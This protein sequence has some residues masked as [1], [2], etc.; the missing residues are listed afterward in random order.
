[1]KKITS[2]IL[3]FLALVVTGCKAEPNPP[4]NVDH[5]KVGEVT[6]RIDLL[7]EVITVEDREEIEAITLL[8][9]ALNEEEQALVTNLYILENAVAVISAIDEEKE[10]ISAAFLAAEAYLKE[11]VP[12]QIT[13]H[14]ELPTTYESE[15]GDISILWGSSHPNTL[16]NTGRVIQGRK[17]SIVTL[18]STLSLGEERY[19]F[20]Q[21]VGVMKIT[22]DPLPTERLSFGY[23]MNRSSF[24]GLTPFQ[25]SALDVINYS[26]GTVVNG[27]VSI[28]G[29]SM[30]DKVLESRRQGV[31]V[32]L[33]LGGYENAA[34]PFS[35]AAQTEAGRIK[36]AASVVETLETYHFD[37]IDMDWEYPGFYSEWPISQTVDSANYTLLMQEIRKQVKIANPDYII[38]AALPGGPYNS[39][40]FE[41]GNLASILDFVHL[42][43]YDLD[44]ADVSTHLTALYPSANTVSKCTVHET[45]QNYMENGMA[46]SQLVVGITFYGREFSLVE[47]AVNPMRSA[48]SSR[49]SIF[50]TEIAEYYLPKIGNG[51]TRYWDAAAKAPYLYDSTLHRTISYDDPESIQYKAEYVIANQ[52]AGTM[53]WEFG[54]DSTDTLLTA[55]YTNL[56]A[57]R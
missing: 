29:L 12:A 28:L 42:M 35:Q 38:S 25:A 4:S 9:E 27:E 15:V 5:V 47:S 1:M 53:F 13:E 14:I 46:A 19:Y 31:R 56:V 20:N 36:L 32:V 24:Q 2:L 39:I 52:L 11:L 16:S 17:D 49:R 45:V 54:E 48:A 23:L 55:I 57:G 8:Y 40:R 51:V 33:C 50:Y 22:F 30:K 7:P 44:A 37:G 18:Y 6:M 43:T 26:F 41:I 10:A 34:I 3:L 21:K